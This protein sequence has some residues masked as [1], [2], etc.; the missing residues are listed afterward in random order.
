[1]RYSVNVSILYKEYPF[2]ERFARAK[3]DGFSA[4]EFWWPSGE[5]LGAV[6]RAVKESGLQAILINFDAG[7]MPAGDRGL[8]SD[9]KRQQAFRDNVPVALGLA[10][11]LGCRMM[12]ALLGVRVQ[13]LSV[14]EQIA[15]ARDNIIFAA[16]LAAKQGATIMIEAV[17]TIENGAYLIHTTKDASEFMKSIGRPNVKL[18]YDAYHMQRMEGNIVA[19]IEKNFG[20][21]GHIQIADSPGRGEPGTGEI[22]YPYVFSKLEELKYDGYVG[23][24]YKP[25]TGKTEESFGWLPKEARGGNLGSDAL[26]IY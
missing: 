5:D 11:R 12:N 18:Q 25:A 3:A 10:D 17:N 6:E 19:T 24:E 21:I 13:D 8:V 7:D 9:P 15:V 23:L 14:E 22:H 4:V 20:D 2:V 26:T 1:V 16:D